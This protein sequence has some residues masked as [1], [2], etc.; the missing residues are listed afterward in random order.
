MRKSRNAF[1]FIRDLNLGNLEYAKKHLNKVKAIKV[2]NISK[3]MESL[4]E[5]FEKEQIEDFNKDFIE[6]NEKYNRTNEYLRE[7]DKQKDRILKG[8][9]FENKGD[10]ESAIALYEVSVECNTFNYYPY[11]RL[12]ILYREEKRYDDEIKIIYKALK[13]LK[14]HSHNGEKLQNLEERLKQVKLLKDEL[15]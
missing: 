3:E 8:K 9:E 2:D 11:E 10:V 5:K 4:L 7:Y 12:M 6:D 1:H 15:I 13:Q 14:A